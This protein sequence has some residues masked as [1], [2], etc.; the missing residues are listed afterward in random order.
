M[1]IAIQSPPLLVHLTFRCRPNFRGIG[2]EHSKLTFPV[3]V[4]R[5]RYAPVHLNRTRFD[6]TD[7]TR[8]AMRSS[9]VGIVVLAVLLSIPTGTLDYWQAWLFMAVFVITSGAIYGV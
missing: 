1:S 5:S 7:V 9:F 2:A 6:L 3:L 8:R 4:A